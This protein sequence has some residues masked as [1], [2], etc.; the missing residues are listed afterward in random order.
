MRRRRNVKIVATLGPASSEP[1]M[2]KRLFQAG[3]D[4]FRINMSHTNHAML[5]TLVANIRAVEAEIGRPIGILADLQGPKL[6]VGAMAGG[7]VDLVVGSSVTIDL[8]PS[9]GDAHHLT[10]PH[11]EIFAVLKPGGQL[12][13][14]DGRLR[15]RIETVSGDSVTAKVEIGGR[16]TDRKGVNVPDA[17]LPIAAL[18]PK[19]RAD[20]D[21]ALEHGVDWI[22]L[23]FV[24]RPEDVAE[25]RKIVAGRAGVL[26]KIEKPAALDRLDEIIELSD[27]VMVA[28]G[29][30]GVELPIEEVPRRQKQITRAARAAGKPVVIATQ[31]LE[32]MISSPMPTRAEVSDVA[33]AVFDGAD[34][35]MLSAE[36]ASGKY[37]VEAVEMMDRVARSIEGD[38]H[39][40]TFIDAQRTEPEATTADAI[41]AA[42]RQVA[43]TVKAAAIVCWTSSGSTALRASRERPSVPVVVLTPIEATGRKLAIAWGLHCVVTEDAI[44]NEDM[45]DRACQIAFREGFAKL[46]QRLVVTAGVPL[47]TPGA[48]NLLRVAFVGGKT[49]GFVG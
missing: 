23:S 42:S 19:D 18:S 6:R 43:H 20:L 49:G 28:R 45:V 16:L 35:V 15:L 47:R 7:G 2:I 46:N 4:V 24:Q 33:T 29:D 44:D 11:K 1:E 31:M 21:R 17:V 5:A 3:A 38:D 10:L 34:A 9:P 22:A 27:A 37:P 8:D 36:S 26:S 40:R 13:I 39:Y 48:T 30:L 25:A 32:S 12:L 14:D 41:T